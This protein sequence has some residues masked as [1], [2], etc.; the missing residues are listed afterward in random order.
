MISKELQNLLIQTITSWQVIGVTLGLIAYFA[1][2][3]Y[4]AQF[5]R[6]VAQKTPK[7]KEPKKKK[8]PQPSEEEEDPEER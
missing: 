1:L 6:K 7:T 3:S 4:V 2:V 8:A 5:R